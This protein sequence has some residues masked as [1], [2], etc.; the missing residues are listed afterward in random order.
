VALDLAAAERLSDVV[1]EAGVP[2][3]MVLTWRYVPE[4][5]ALL[6]AMAGHEPPG[7]RGGS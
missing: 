6:A 2:T 5:R 4:V 7:G 1:Q 3:Q